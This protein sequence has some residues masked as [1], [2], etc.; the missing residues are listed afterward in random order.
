MVCAHEQKQSHP[1]R[2]YNAVQC[3]VL[4]V[5]VLPGVSSVQGSFFSMEILVTVLRIVCA[6][7]YSHMSFFSA[8]TLVGEETIQSEVI[9]ALVFGLEVRM[10]LIV[11]FVYW[12]LSLRKAATF[13]CFTLCQQHTL[14]NSLVLH[15]SMVLLVESHFSACFFPYCF[16]ASPFLREHFSSKLIHQTQR[17]YLS[18]FLSSC[19][20]LVKQ[21]SNS[22]KTANKQQF[23]DTVSCCKFCLITCQFP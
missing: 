17:G 23:S 1:I 20:L 21:A 22:Q 4:F 3:S 9:Q 2:L 10:S 12:P 6:S 11:L 15:F 16:A 7:D 19:S 5:H 14:L 8:I 13:G 18:S